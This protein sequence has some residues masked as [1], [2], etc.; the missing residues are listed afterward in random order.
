MPSRKALCYPCLCPWKYFLLPSFFIFK[1]W[2]R[3][4]KRKFDTIIFFYVFVDLV[5]YDGLFVIKQNRSVLIYERTL[6]T[7]HHIFALFLQSKKEGKDQESIQSS[8]TPDPGYQWES[9]K[10][11][12]RHHKR[13][14]RGQ[15][16]PSRWPQDNN[17]Q[18]RTKAKQTHN[19]NNMNDPQKKYRLG[20][21]SKY[22]L[23]EGLDR[24]NY[25]NLTL[26]SDVDQDI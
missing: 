26:N 17:K 20:M 22:I 11:T 13:E 25:T 12:I 14:P 15:P 3:K 4:T 24:F 23:P 8:T 18:T 19:R 21:V 2:Q 9:N 5:Y 1:E 10:L 16:F 7:H 6:K